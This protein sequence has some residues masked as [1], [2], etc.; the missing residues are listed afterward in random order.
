MRGRRKI[1]VQ[2]AMRL[3]KLSEAELLDGTSDYKGPTRR[4]DQLGVRYWFADDIADWL[5]VRRK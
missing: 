4:S 3:T 1:Y 2:E 5:S